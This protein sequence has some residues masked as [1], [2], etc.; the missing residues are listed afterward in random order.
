MVQSI[1][2][3]DHR[4][5]ASANRQ[6]FQLYYAWKNKKSNDDASL[7][8]LC[9]SCEQA[10]LIPQLVKLP[11]NPSQ[12]DVLVHYL[13]NVSTVKGAKLQAVLCL[14]LH[15]KLD[16]A[17][18]HKDVYIPAT[19]DDD[20]DLFQSGML[21]SAMVDSYAKNFPLFSSSVSSSNSSSSPA[22]IKH[23]STQQQ[24]QQTQHATPRN[25]KYEYTLLLASFRLC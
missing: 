2:N 3:D 17:L 20:D 15:G 8:D 23:Q 18:K 25:E 1:G 24:Q 10:K 9:K 22:I 12:L 14:L 21:L 6:L 19:G 4:S 16:V 5:V 7:I 11:W 13:L